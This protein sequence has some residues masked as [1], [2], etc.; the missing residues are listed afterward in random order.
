MTLWRGLQNFFRAILNKWSPLLISVQL[1]CCFCL[2]TKHWGFVCV[3]AHNSLSSAA[4]CKGDAKCSEKKLEERKG[5]QQ[6]PE[7][8][9]RNSRSIIFSWVS[10]FLISCRL[11]LLQI[12]PLFP[13]VGGLCKLPGSYQGATFTLIG[14]LCIFVQFPSIS[15]FC[16][17]LLINLQQSPATTDNSLLVRLGEG[18]SVH[19]AL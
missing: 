7:T 15:F 3:H 9:K 16:C 6:T 4:F 1:C 19:K 2:Q 8:H 17:F 18:S 10:W 5:N 12:T 13:V 11:L 14:K